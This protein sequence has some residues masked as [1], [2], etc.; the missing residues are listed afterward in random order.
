MSFFEWLTDATPII[1]QLNP[2]FRVA[3]F[4][5]QTAFI[6]GATGL[7]EYEKE[8][9]VVQVKKERIVIMGENL[10]INSF[11]EGDMMVCGKIT[12]IETA[13]K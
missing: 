6:E 1:S 2:P 5:S 11:A 12:A 10:A 13:I 7:E 9:V 8:R 3:L 4:G